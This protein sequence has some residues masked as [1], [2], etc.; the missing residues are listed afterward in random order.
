MSVLWNESENIYFAKTKEYFR[1]VTSSYS[2]GNYRSAVVMLYSVAICDMLFKLQELK[3]MHNDSIAETILLEIEKSRNLHDNKSKA[4][5]EK[6]LVDKIYKDTELLDLVEFTNLNHL[7]DHRNFSAHPALN[8]NYELISPSKETTIAHIKNILESILVKPPIFIKNITDMLVEDLRGIKDIYLNQ[9]DQLK[10]YLNNKYFSK[11]HNT[12]KE[13]IF[14][15]LWKFCF[16][17]DDDDCKANRDINAVV[18]GILYETDESIFTK[19]IKDS[20]DYFS[21]DKGKGRRKNLVILVSKYPKI[22]DC[23]SEDTKFRIND[24]INNNSDAKYIS[25]FKFE[26]HLEYLIAERLYDIPPAYIEKMKAHYVDKGMNEEFISYLI[27]CFGKSDSFDTANSRFT[28]DIEPVLREMTKTNFKKLFE[29]LKSNSQIYGRA[30]HESSKCKIIEAA[31]E[32][33]GDGYAEI[34][35]EI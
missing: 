26:Q 34:E 3:D 16:N 21:A 30:Q 18:L 19:I 9:E 17:L 8:E 27:R 2:N 29:V 1:E 28:Y 4:R 11:M 6:E 20:P 32:T 10:I 12:M 14:K 7:Y 15:A 5:W 25:W 13:K 33:L 23:L 35:G 22:Y 31:K 24:Y